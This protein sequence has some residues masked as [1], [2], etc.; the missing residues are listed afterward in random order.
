MKYVKTFESYN[1]INLDLRFNDY[2]EYM[3]AVEYF[4]EESQFF[5]NDTNSEFKSITFYCTDQND[6]DITEAEITN[7]LKTKGFNNYYFEQE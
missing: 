6:A 3:K 2:D 1:S 7:D 4:N 5:P